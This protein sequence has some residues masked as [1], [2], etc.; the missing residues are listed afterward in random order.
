MVAISA[1]RAAAMLDKREYYCDFSGCYYSPWYSWQRWVVLGVLL[2]V[3]AIVLLACACFS[4]R[5]R[6]RRGLSPFYG[7]AWAAPPPAY[8]VHNIGHQN[9]T[10]P[11]YGG[12][13][14]ASNNYNT[15]SGFAG[16]PPA[17]MG[18]NADYYGGQQG[19]PPRGG[20]E[21][22]NFGSG[23]GPAPYIPPRPQEAHVAKH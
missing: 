6:R 5:R 16:S 21:M 17:Y 7:T 4:A 15:N 11:Q 23:S 13:T 8:D 20:Y 9:T 2:V 10:G 19:P 1:E 14:Y 12:Q 22:N 3:T 18:A